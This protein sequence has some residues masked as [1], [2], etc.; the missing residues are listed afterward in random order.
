MS[1]PAM[2]ATP[3]DG[4]SQGG[5]IDPGIGGRHASGKGGRHGTGITGR[6]APEHAEKRHSLFKSILEIS[7]VLEKS[8]I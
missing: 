3:S 6:H 1:I 7:P 5:R 4:V 2:T 8:K